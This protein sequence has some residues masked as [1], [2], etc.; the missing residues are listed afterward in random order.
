EELLGWDFLFALRVL[1]DDIPLD[2][3]TIDGL[4]GRALD[5]WFHAETSRCRFSRYRAALK[6]RLSALGPT[7]AASRLLAAFDAIALTQAAT[8]PSAFCELAAALSPLGSFPGNVASALV[9]LA[10]SAGVAPRVRAR[11]VDALAGGG[12]LTPEVVAALV[13]LATS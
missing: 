11:A 12:A 9:G 13:G 2:T 7:R 4:L 6:E 1:A 3:V 5:E 8:A 10:T